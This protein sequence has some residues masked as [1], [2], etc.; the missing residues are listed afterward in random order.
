MIRMTELESRL[1]DHILEIAVNDLKKEG[2]KIGRIL[3]LTSQE[4]FPPVTAATAT[5]GKS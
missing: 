4:M 3:L 2:W 5:S 1:G